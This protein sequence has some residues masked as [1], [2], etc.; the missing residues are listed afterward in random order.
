MS[1]IKH[2]Y[3]RDH[4]CLQF[5]SPNAESD[6]DNGKEIAWR[7][8]HSP[9]TMD[10]TLAAS[11]GLSASLDQYIIRSYRRNQVA[12]D[13]YG[14]QR[15]FEISEDMYLELMVEFLATLKFT[16]TDRRIT[17]NA[18]HSGWEALGWGA[19]SWSSPHGLASTRTPKWTLPSSSHSCSTPTVKHLLN[20]MQ[21]ASGVTS[22]GPHKDKMPV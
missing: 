9:K 10:W 22:P 18:L 15:L 2:T 17:K 7:K 21:P 4:I 5:H 19:L 11:I 8:F 16:L 1:K 3:N 6:R 20:S 12:F 13:D 14:W